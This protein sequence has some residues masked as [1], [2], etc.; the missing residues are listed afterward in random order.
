MLDP[1]FLR[2]I[3]HR[4][5]HDAAKGVIENTAPAFEAAIARGYAIECDLEA[6]AGG[7]PVVFH[8]DTLDR[9]TTGTGP[10]ARLDAADLERVRFRGTDVAGIPTFAEV[11]EFCGAR[12]PL[13]VEI[14]S[15]WSAPNRAFLSEIARLA[16]AHEG[17]I[18]LMSFDPSVMQV[19]RSLAP[20][21]P[22]GIVSG[23]YRDDSGT[24]WWPELGRFRSWRLANLLESASA[25]PDFI[26][27]E[28]QALPTPATRLVRS[29]YRLPLLTWTVRTDED[30]RRA[31]RYA[32]APIFEGYE[33]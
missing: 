31:A 32:D 15:D 7:L 8:D 18:A 17:P 23:R 21:V 13:V 25:A 26:A 2:P 9:L 28:V 24:L 19:I 14:K 22:R 5:L 4:G 30:R 10:V 12:V 1:P 33:P 3:A 11:L 29:L 20:G 6:A 27:Y 16:A